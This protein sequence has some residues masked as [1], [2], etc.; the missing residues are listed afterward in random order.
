MSA[1]VVPSMKG[2][3]ATAC[4]S[5]RL[6]KCPSVVRSGATIGVRPQSAR[7]TTRAAYADEILLAL[8]R[9]GAVGVGTLTLRRDDYGGNRQ[10]ERVA[11][12]GRELVAIDID[13]EQALLETIHMM[14]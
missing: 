13:K 8:S 10:A 3:M 7:S 9:R 4:S 6:V 5:R 2:K 11:Q 12:V 1:E 14:I